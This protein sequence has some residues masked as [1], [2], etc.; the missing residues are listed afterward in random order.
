[1]ELVWFDRND[2]GGLTDFS[3]ESLFADGS[4]Y[5]NEAF[6]MFVALNNTIKGPNPSGLCQDQPP[7]NGLPHFHP[8]AWDEFPM[9]LHGCPVGE[10]TC[11][12]RGQGSR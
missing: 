11:S 7:T 6:A 3:N 8:Y 12:V 5:N 10:P 9:G 2:T 4:L 1:M